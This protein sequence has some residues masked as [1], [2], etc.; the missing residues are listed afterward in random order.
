MV[1]YVLPMDPDG[2]KND[3][4]NKNHILMGHVRGK[5]VLKHSDFFI[6]PCYV[7]IAWIATMEVGAE[8]TCNIA[9]F[10]QLLNKGSSKVKGNKVRINLK[11]IMVE[12]AGTNYCNVLEECAS[13]FIMSKVVRCQLHYKKDVHQIFHFYTTHIYLYSHC[14]TWI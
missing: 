5:Q 7:Q 8:S 11:S 14:V 4:Q 6:F 10:W 13:G 3:L 12:K 9:F 1:Q 2:P